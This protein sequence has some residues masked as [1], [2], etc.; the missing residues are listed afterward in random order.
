MELKQLGAG[1][2][3]VHCHVTLTVEGLVNGAVTLVGVGGAGVHGTVVQSYN[4]YTKGFITNA[5]LLLV[6]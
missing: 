2:D 4:Y 6:D 3:L 5:Y 1:P